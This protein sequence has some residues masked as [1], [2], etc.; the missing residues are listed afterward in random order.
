M[1][2]LD[3]ARVSVVPGT[4]LGPQY[5]NHVRINFATSPDLITKALTQ[6]AAL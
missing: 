2:M 5:T 3:E 4:E 6:I 1:R